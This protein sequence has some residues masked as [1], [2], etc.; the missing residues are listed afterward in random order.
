VRLLH[1]YDPHPQLF[2]AY[3]STLAALAGSDE[4][5]DVLRRFEFALLGELGY[6]FDL[7][8]DGHSGEVVQAEGWYHYHPEHGLVARQAGADPAQP[9]FRGADLLAIA[10]NDFSGAARATAK[11]LLRLV[12]ALQLGD[13]P[14][15]SRDLFR[16][17]ARAVRRPQA[18][19]AEEQH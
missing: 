7:D 18:A 5:D 19:G 10:S 16:A 13:A 14:L 6:G 4:V 1:R 15:R 12:L 2:A 3:A 11:R 9:A 8:L 17:H